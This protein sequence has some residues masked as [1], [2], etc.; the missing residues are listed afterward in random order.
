MNFLGFI[1]NGNK[2]TYGLQ[3]PAFYPASRIT[4][5]SVS[6]TAD[7]V[8]TYRQ[9]LNELYALIDYGKLNYNSALNV[10]TAWYRLQNINA[11]NETI[12]VCNLGGV[13]NIFQATLN[14]RET[15]SE[16]YNATVNNG[17]FTATD[18]SAN[19]PTSGIEF[20]VYY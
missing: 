18:R 5:E 15:S 1:K 7:G 20:T 9:I 4:H 16:Y 10:G 14:I 2:G 3:M 6:V 11:S 12:F 13:T 17:G 8:K 19:V